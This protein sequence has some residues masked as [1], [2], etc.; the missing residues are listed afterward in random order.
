MAIVNRAA[1][2]MAEGVSVECDVESFWA[3]ASGLGGSYGR[4]IL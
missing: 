3:H 2:N 4:F 1:V